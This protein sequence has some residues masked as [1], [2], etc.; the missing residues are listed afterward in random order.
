MAQTVADSN[1]QEILDLL[2]DAQEG[3]L[4]KPH[5]VASAVN[6]SPIKEMHAL[7]WVS[8]AWWIDDQSS[9]LMFNNTVYVNE[10]PL[11]PIASS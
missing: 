3:V 7:D 6:P 5:E 1:P 8:A 9:K 2:F 10:L 4:S 11:D